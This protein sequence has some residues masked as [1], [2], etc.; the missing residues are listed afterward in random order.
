VDVLI[1]APVVL[2]SV[3]A[4]LAYVVAAAA[5]FVWDAIRTVMALLH[6]TRET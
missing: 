5:V 1:G 4:M 6:H 3:F 2:I